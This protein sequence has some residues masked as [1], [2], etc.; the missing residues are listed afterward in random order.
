MKVCPACH[1]IIHESQM[2]VMHTSTLFGCPKIWVGRYIH[3]TC[4]HNLGIS[5]PPEDKEA[6]DNDN[7]TS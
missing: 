1:E 6:I 7:G 4:A 5:I 2:A 3:S